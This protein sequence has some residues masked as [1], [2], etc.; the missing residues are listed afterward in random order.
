MTTLHTTIRSDESL[1]AEIMESL[2]RRQEIRW[3]DLDSLTVGVQQGVVTLSGY[4]NK[5]SNFNLINKIV[6]SIPGVI[7]VDNQLIIDRNLTLRI[8]QALAG[9]ARTR[10]LIMP[11]GTTHGWVRFGGAVPT[12]E[13][14]AVVEEVTAGVP[15]VRGIVSLPKLP[16][17]KHNLERCAVQPV[18]SA[19]VFGDNGQLGAVTQVIIQPRSRLVTHIVMEAQGFQNGAFFLRE[20][21]IPVDAIERVDEESVF[22]KRKTPSLSVI[23]AFDPSTYPPAHQDWQIPY[24]YKK[25]TVRWS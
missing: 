4:L 15:G 2:W 11:V 9:D 18:I 19:K 16:H 1:G 20:Y 14:Q 6:R 8:A 22:L 3:L 25:G 23:P 24:P 17:G 7:Q 10:S 13:L 21:L 12:C 5:E